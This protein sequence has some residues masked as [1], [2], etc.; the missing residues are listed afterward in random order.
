MQDH[1]GRFLGDLGAP[2]AHGHTNV[3]L[4]EGR[5]IVDPVA[6]HAHSVARPLISGNEVQLLLRADSGKD[7][8]LQD[9]LAILFRQVVA[10]TEVPAMNHLRAIVVDQAHRLCDFAR[11]D[12]VIAGDHHHTNAGLLT[13]LQRRAY[14][15]AR[16]V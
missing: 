1:V 12:R 11:R 16:R 3:G 14:L 13:G 10:V 2:L 6:G 8:R 9:A 7:W 15:L 4:F 5:S